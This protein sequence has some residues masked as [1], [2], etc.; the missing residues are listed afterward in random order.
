MPRVQ[1]FP[2]RDQL[3][4][5]YALVLFVGSEP[6]LL[7]LILTSTSLSSPTS[8]LFYLFPATAVLLLVSTALVCH[9]PF[10]LA[11]PP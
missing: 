8:A 10:E 7:L 11:R 5:P 6:I 9:V 1:V 4:A 2:F 3:H